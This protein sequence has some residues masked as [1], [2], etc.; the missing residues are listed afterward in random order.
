MLQDAKLSL[1]QLQAH[2]TEAVLLIRRLY[3]DCRLVH[4]DLS[5]FNILVHQVGQ[6]PS[7]PSP[8]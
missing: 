3:Q 7:D 1:Q 5:E 4:A 2:Y 8:R 6:L